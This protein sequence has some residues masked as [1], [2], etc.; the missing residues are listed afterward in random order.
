MSL[1]KLYL[2]A[3]KMA[4]EIVQFYV[5]LIRA[6]RKTLEDVPE[7]WRD[8]VQAELERMK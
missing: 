1:L 7:K 8:A 5:K 4:S 6:E 3:S 2:E